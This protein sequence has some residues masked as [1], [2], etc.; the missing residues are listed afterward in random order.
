MAVNR[1]W[2]PDTMLSRSRSSP[3]NVRRVPSAVESCLQWQN[4]GTASDRT[5]V[6]TTLTTTKSVEQTRDHP[7]QQLAEA[8]PSGYSA[9]TRYDGRSTPYDSHQPAARHASVSFSY[10]SK[11]SFLAFHDQDGEESGGDVRDPFSPFP[12]LCSY[13]SYCFLGPSVDLSLCSASLED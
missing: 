6:R 11:S 12:F 4:A 7:Q 9:S 13:F 3:L 1:L 10:T 2:Y 5:V 8:Y